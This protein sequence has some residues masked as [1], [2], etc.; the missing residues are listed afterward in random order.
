MLKGNRY[1]DLRYFTGIKMKQS[2][3]RNIRPHET[4]IESVM[5]NLFKNI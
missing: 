3:D 5:N 2:L 1:S 4:E